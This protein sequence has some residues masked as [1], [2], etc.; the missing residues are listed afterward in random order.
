MGRFSR[1]QDEDLTVDKL[2]T[3]DWA[4][5]PCEVEADRCLQG[6]LDV[7][8]VAG[9]GHVAIRGRFHNELDDDASC[10]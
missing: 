2:H 10:Q 7:V 6:N 3:Q 8:Q 5:D 1:I 4:P 9:V